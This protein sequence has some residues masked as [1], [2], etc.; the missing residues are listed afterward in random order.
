VFYCSHRE[1]QYLAVTWPAWVCFSWQHW[2]PWQISQFRQLP[3]FFH[4]LPPIS[5]P[6]AM[7][8][9]PQF[10]GKPRPSHG[11]HQSSPSLSSRSTWPQNRS[12]LV[13]I[14]VITVIFL[15]TWKVHGALRAC[16]WRR[17]SLP[18]HF[19][20]SQLTPPKPTPLPSPYSAS[21]A[22]SYS[23][24]YSHTLPSS[25]QGRGRIRTI[26]FFKKRHEVLTRQWASN[27]WHAAAT[28]TTCHPRHQF[29]VIFL[30][31]APPSQHRYPQPAT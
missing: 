17:P 18:S 1:L 6:T 7:P 10:T 26:D 11:K 28:S 22:Y 20:P 14:T 30:L 13:G 9:R 12:T 23:Y 2:A 25:R 24:A 4:Q 29:P 3:Q 5:A 21:S 8:T 19:D 31:G 16:V 15:C 27:F